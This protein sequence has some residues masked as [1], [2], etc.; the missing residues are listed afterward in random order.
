MHPIDTDRIYFNIVI[1]FSDRYGNGQT[2]AYYQQ[3]LDEAIVNKPKDYYLSIVRFQ[4]PTQT[5]PILIPQVLNYNTSPQPLNSNVAIPNTN[6]NILRYSVTLSWGNPATPGAT[7][8]SEQTF[9]T[10][11][12]YNTKNP[13]PPNLSAQNPA[14]TITPY[15][16]IFRYTDFLEMVNNA[17]ASAFTNLAGLTVLPVGSRAPYL[18]FDPATELISLIAQTAHYN[19]NLGGGSPS[20]INRISIFFNNYLSDLLDGLS[21]TYNPQT[22]FGRDYMLNVYNQFNNFYNPPFLAPTIPPEYFSMTQDYRTLVNWNSF[23]SLQIVSN[24]LPVRQ[25]IIPRPI[26]GINNGRVNTQGILKDFIPLVE[27]GPEARTTVQYSLNGPYQLIDLYGEVPITK[28]DMQVYW[29]DQYE[30]QYPLYID[31]NQT[32]TLKMVF[33]KKASFHGY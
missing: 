31:T 24:L 26:D 28:I 30:N 13:Q 32:L 8:Y 23:K 17:L 9:V 22:A 20:P 14:P 5:I 15:Y 27:L 21:Y 4:I 18:I 33:I 2:P 12:P 1:P 29:T 3:Q 10:F 6:P 25:E 11:I 19:Q 7:V 16:Y